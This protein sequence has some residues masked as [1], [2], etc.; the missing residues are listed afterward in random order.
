MNKFKRFSVALVAALIVGCGSYTIKDLKTDID[1]GIELASDLY[2]KA[3]EVTSGINPDW[4]EKWCRTGST[5]GQTGFG[6][7]N[8]CTALQEIADSEVR[9]AAARLCAEHDPA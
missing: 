9:E 1:A 5:V 4:T 8:P 3:C 7:V 2:N 6:P